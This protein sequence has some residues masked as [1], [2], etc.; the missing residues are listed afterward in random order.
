MSLPSVE[1]AVR[2]IQEGGSL[3]DLMEAVGVIRVSAGA[4]PA[5]LLPALRHAAVV[6]EQAAFALYAMTGRRLPGDST[7]LDTDAASWRRFL[8][9]RGAALKALSD[10]IRTLEELDVKVD[11]KSVAHL[12]IAP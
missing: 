8:E 3:A 4:S 1:E 6:R 11:L 9:R 2:R 12:V 7:P 5:A 10:G